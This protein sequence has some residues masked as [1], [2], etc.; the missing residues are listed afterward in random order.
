M[1]EKLQV[2]MCF[3]GRRDFYMVFE[4]ATYFTLS[5]CEAEYTV[6]SSWVCQAIWLQ[7]LSNDSH[8]QQ[9]DPTEI[10]VDN[11]SALSLAKNSTF[12]D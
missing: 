9:G 3:Y 1:M 2:V 4:E 11:K 7:N 12:Y 10:F 5:S 6:V 8:L